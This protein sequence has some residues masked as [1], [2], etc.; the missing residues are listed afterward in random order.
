MERLNLAELE[1]I[2]ERMGSPK[3]K[4]AVRVVTELARA[5]AR[6]YEPL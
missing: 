1:K 5:E 2:A 3:M 4:R 6:E